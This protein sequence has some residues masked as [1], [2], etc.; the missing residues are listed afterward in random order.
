MTSRGSGR[1]PSAGGRRGRHGPQSGAGGPALPPGR[2]VRLPNKIA[3][4]GT[5]LKVGFTGRTQPIS[6]WKNRDEAFADVARSLREVATNLAAR[7]MSRDT[8]DSSGKTA[9]P[10][11]AKQVRI[12]FTSSI[13]S[14]LVII[15]SI[16]IIHY[17]SQPTN[18]LRYGVD[19][20]RENTEQIAAISGRTEVKVDEVLGRIAAM[21]QE[22]D[23]KLSSEKR[24]GIERTI[25][26]IQVGNKA[27]ELSQHEPK[28]IELAENLKRIVD[29]FEQDVST[30]SLSDDQ[31]MILA[32]ARKAVE[33]GSLTIKAPSDVWVYILLT[34]PGISTHW[35]RLT[36]K[37]ISLPKGEYTI[38]IH[39]DNNWMFRRIKVDNI[40]H[41]TIQRIY[42]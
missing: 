3:Y 28:V 25:A 36:N 41:F 20:I 42:G 34:G 26:L 35:R 23:D 18:K 31:R 22:L 15:I 21:R 2:T 13:V 6:T 39:I 38:K 37:P 29:E 11:A 40:S 7:S 9:G 19:R 27:I 16:F 33:R 24:R 5:A 10:V 8:E 4:S 12:R 32:L 17:L 14:I 1:S 30:A